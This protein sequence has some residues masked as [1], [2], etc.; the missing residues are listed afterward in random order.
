MDKLYQYGVCDIPHK[1]IKSN[2]MSRTQQV[3][4]NQLKEY[5]LCSLPAR[6]GDPHNSI[7]G[8]LLFASYANDVQ[9]LTQGRTIM[10]AVDT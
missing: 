3:A 8:P 2:P 6:Y 4:N 5:S 9:Y 10:Y 1:L 7:L